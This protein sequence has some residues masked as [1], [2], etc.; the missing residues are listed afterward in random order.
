MVRSYGQAVASAM[1]ASAAAAEEGA[2]GGGAAP[3]T[4]T[5]RRTAMAKHFA[6]PQAS[7]ASRAR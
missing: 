1:Q 6:A 2:A 5:E 4:R 7:G 3:M